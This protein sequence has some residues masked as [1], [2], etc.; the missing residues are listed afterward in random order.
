MDKDN[1]WSQYWQQGNKTSFG[2][3]HEHGYEGVLKKE[4]D[5]IFSKL[6]PGSS[7]IDLCTG[8]LSLIRMASQFD[9][10][11]AE[12]NFTGVDYANI[13]TDDFVHNNDNVVFLTGV[14]IEKMDCEDKSFDHVI[15]NFGI[16]YSNVERSIIEIARILKKN[17]SL[18]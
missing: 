10:S 5:S 12:I 1:Y 7:V 8:N 15:S 11:F 3:K 4:W 9:N 18:T 17:G 14:N 16:E 2:D 6:K 13:V